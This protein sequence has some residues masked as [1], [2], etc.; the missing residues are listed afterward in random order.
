M[1]GIFDLHVYARMPD[2]QNHGREIVD[3]RLETVIRR[4]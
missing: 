4:G 1:T 3:T 2:G